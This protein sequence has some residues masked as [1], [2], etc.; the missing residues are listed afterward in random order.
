MLNQI[1]YLL[2]QNCQL[3]PEFLFCTLP[4]L[5]LLSQKPRD[6]FIPPSFSPT[7]CIWSL[8]PSKYSWNLVMRILK[9]SYALIWAI[10]SHLNHCC[11]LS[12]DWSR[13]L[14]P[15]IHTPIPNIFIITKSWRYPKC[16]SVRD[17]SGQVLYVLLSDTYN[18]C[19]YK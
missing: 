12:Q 13:P 16:L 7:I 9:Y 10:I 11:H 4:H 2:F 14:P 18:T 8:S 5:H 3:S 17:W 19:I 15:P 1:H 6:S